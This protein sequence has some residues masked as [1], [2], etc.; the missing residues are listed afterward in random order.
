MYFPKSQLITDLFTN[1]GE[2]RIFPT[3][4]EYKGYY[5]KTTNGTQYTGKN[6][7][8]GTPQQLISLTPTPLD[9]DDLSPTIIDSLVSYSN[10][11]TPPSRFLPQL[12]ITTPTENN[13]TKGDFNRYFCKKTNE[14]KYME[15][16]K[17]TY[18]ELISKT[19][20]IAWD[21][22]DPEIIIWYITPNI[23]FNFLKNK[24][25][26]QNL[27]VIEQWYGFSQYLKEDYTKYSL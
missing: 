21:L 11:P 16:S 25:T 5:F 6:P 20:Q 2:Y 3:D 9:V 4:E 7:Q 22:Y 1:G 13:Y 23:E 14:I 8:D 17:T 24:Q 12:S 26:I 15:I 18:D 19:P 27:E 10:K